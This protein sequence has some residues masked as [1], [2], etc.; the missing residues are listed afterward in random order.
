MAKVL[1]N[2]SSLNGIADAIR[3]K[4]GSTNTYK[5]NEMAAAIT[6]IETG[7]GSDNSLWDAETEANLISNRSAIT[8]I[9]LPS[10]I[11]NIDNYTFARCVNLNIDSLPETI[12]SI[13]SFAFYGCDAITNMMFHSNIT[14]IDMY[15]FG[16]CTGLQTV[17]FEGTPALTI[18]SAFAN[19]TGLQT[20]TFKG[21]PASI[22]S[23]AFADCTNLTTINVPWAEGEVANAPWGAT[24][25]TI[26]YNYT[27]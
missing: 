9:A 14:L 10:G 3:G 24:N 20:V 17:T 12:T 11:N 23:Y 6:A 21:T 26:N 18:S 16:Y 8:T 4:N 7:S 27:E 15:A 13:S 22:G 25:A 5:P 19:C 2:E 1:V